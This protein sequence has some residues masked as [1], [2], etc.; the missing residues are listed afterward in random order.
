M[1]SHFRGA[2]HRNKPTT[3]NCTSFGEGSARV[4]RVDFGVVHD[5][6]GIPRIHHAGECPG[7]LDRSQQ[8]DAGTA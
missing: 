8:A 5:E 7:A 1:I 3:L 6:I 2:A 4:H